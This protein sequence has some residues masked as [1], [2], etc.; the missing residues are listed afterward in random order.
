MRERGTLSTWQGAQLHSPWP[1]LTPGPLASAPLL[2]KHRTAGW[3]LPGKTKNEA[4]VGMANTQACLERFLPIIQHSPYPRLH[5]NRHPST[6]L[7]LTLSPSLGPP[8]SRPK[9]SGPTE[10]IPCVYGQPPD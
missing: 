10:V 2:W 8:P 7:M 3:F 9:P 4:T 6:L 1:L 5:P